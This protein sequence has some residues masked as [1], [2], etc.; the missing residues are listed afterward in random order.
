MKTASCVSRLSS[1]RV[2]EIVEWPGGAP[3]GAKTQKRPQT[4]RIGGAPGDRPLRIQPLEVADQER[5]IGDANMLRFDITIDPAPGTGNWIEVTLSTRDGSAVKGEDYGRGIFVPRDP[6][7]PNG[8]SGRWKGITHFRFED[9]ETTQSVYVRVIDDHVEDSGE[10]ME[11]DAH[12]HRVQGLEW[13]DR[14][15]PRKTTG[16]GTIYND[17]EVGQNSRASVADVEAREADGEMDFTITLSEP[18]SADVSVLYRMRDGSAVAGADYTETRGWAE[19][20]AGD[21]AKTITVPII[22]DD[23]DEQREN[24]DFQLR[25]FINLSGGSGATGTIIDE[26]VTAPPPATTWARRGGPGHR[27]RAHGARRDRCLRPGVGS[28]RDGGAAIGAR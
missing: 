6:P 19:F 13:H 21:R 11:L 7:D 22:D 12:I 17:E 18:V 14:P 2:R 25:D 15:P 27:R 10:T 1:R 8:Y 24:F 26:D 3:G 16:I 9:N 28:D 23:V 5:N 20:L 4:Q